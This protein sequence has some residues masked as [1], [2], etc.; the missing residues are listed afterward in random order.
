ML[1]S[2]LKSKRAIEA[3]IAIMRAFVKLRKMLASNDDLKRKLMAMERKYDS[4]FK[5]VFDAIKQLINVCPVTV[6]RMLKFVI[7]SVSE[8]ISS[9][10]NKGDC[11]VA[12]AC[13]ERNEWVPRND[14][15][16]GKGR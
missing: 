16:N 13:P 6:I 14:K 15:R 5:V 8:A 10:C 9:L 12:G 1:S 3:H 2:V 4:Q 11:R 7:A